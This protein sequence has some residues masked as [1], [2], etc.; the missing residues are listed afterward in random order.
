[1]AVGRLATVAATEAVAAGAAAAV[2]AVAAVVAAAKEA[3]LLAAGTR[4]GKMVEAVQRVVA[5][6]IHRA[7]PEVEAAAT[8]VGA[9]VV[10]QEVGA[11]AAGAAEATERA[12][13]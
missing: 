2:V 6:N 13:R 5:G 8:Q 7:V 10:W 3:V 12:R 1:M 9:A 4:V 11:A